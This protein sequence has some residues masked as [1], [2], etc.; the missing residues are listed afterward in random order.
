MW[1]RLALSSSKA[2]FS[3]EAKSINREELRSTIVALGAP[4][5]YLSISP[6]DVH[7]PLAY[8]F[9]KEGSLP[10][11]LDAQPAEATDRAFRQPQ[12][13]GIPVRLAEF[14]ATLVR[15]TLEKLFGGVEEEQ[16]PG[17]YGPLAGYYG[18]VE[19]QNRGTLHVHLLL[20]VKGT[21]CPRDMQTRLQE[22]FAFR[23][24]VLTYLK[25]IILADPADVAPE[26]E[27]VEEAVE[28]AA[29]EAAEEATAAAAG[30]G[31]GVAVVVPEQPVSY[32]PCLD[33]ADPNFLALRQLRHL[34]VAL[35]RVA[36]Q[37]A[38]QP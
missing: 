11:A 24:A 28:E 26:A 31:E 19:T 27:A 29:E 1:R 8:A 34:R 10:L 6:L 9:C 23:A 5:L 12:A 25:R 30:E 38:L 16:G 14:F 35:E 3:Q 36:G 32:Q 13:V 4:F 17:I 15:L 7:H 18:M 22:D 37:A 21:P 2:A 33:P 20:W